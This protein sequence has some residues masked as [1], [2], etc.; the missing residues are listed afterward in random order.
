MI[1][2]DII[3]PTF[4]GLKVFVVVVCNDLI[5]IDAISHTIKYTIGSSQ[6]EDIVL[7]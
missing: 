6:I 1:M 5:C 7:L 4:L 2:H 3:S